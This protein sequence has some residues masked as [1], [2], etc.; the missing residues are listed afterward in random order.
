M[1]QS[2]RIA[3][4][5]V[6]FTALFLTRGVSPSSSSPA[7]V[8][9]AA[10]MNERR[11]DHTSTLLPDGRV[12]IV[13]GMVEN[14]VFLNSAEL[15]D[16]KQRAFLVTGRMQSSRVEHTATLLSNGTVLIAGGLAGRAFEGGPGVVASTEIYD[17]ATGH[18]T[19]GPLMSTPRTGHAAVLL[20]NNKVL[21]VGGA[22][23]NGPL[24]SAEIYDP[25]SNRF[26]ATSSMHTARVARSA[27]V[28][29]DGRVLVTGGGNGRSAEVYDPIVAMWRSVGDM[30]SVRQKHAATLLLDGRV[31]ITGGAPDGHWHPLRTAEIFDPHTNKFT[32]VADME[33]PR[34][35]LPGAT[36]SLKNGE[37]LVAGGAAEVEIFD[38]ATGRFSRAGSVA[39]PHFFAA[40]TLLDDGRVLITGGYGLPNGRPNG[41]VSTEQSWIYQP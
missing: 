27:V 5:C 40:A 22:D 1:N 29:E 31:L 13:G 35:K 2:I 12:L 24:A 19:A 15:Y 3:F 18:F 37:V 20:G 8:V 34:F 23:N 11:A 41:P 7:G 25:V 28:L 4:G 30:T 6:A 14:G 36:A 21:M 38:S 9:R 10:S 16:P 26:I 17:P 39:E 32:A 33:L